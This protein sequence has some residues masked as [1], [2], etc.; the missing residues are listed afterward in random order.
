MHKRLSVHNVSF[1]GAT[2]PEL[3]SHWQALGL[4][5]LSP[6]DSQLFDADL[7]KLVDENGYS[8]QTVYHLFI[9]R[10]TC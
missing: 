1:Q 8:V 5:R 6:I 10:S 9:S 3:H 4:T 2:L 7:S